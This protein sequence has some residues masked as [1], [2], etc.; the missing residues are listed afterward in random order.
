MSAH[1]KSG[2]NTRRQL[3]ETLAW[4]TVGI[5]TLT[6]PCRMR[7]ETRTWV[8]PPS[9]FAGLFADPTAAR[10]TGHRF[11]AMGTERRQLALDFARELMAE[12]EVGGLA[13]K[14]AFIA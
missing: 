12:A 9:G 8:L 14:T 4:L 13:L 11:L 5:G 1:P 7:A 6:L 10:A 3:L 2:G